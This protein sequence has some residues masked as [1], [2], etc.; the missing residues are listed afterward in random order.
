MQSGEVIQS[1]GGTRAVLSLSAKVLTCLALI[2]SLP[3]MALQ[4]FGA[5]H[6]PTVE[7]HD[8]AGVLQVEA[9]QE[10][11]AS[12]E[13][14]DE[15][16]LEVLTMPRVDA[17][18]NFNAAVLEW[19]RINEPDW[20]SAADP[21]Y[22]ADGLVVL[23]VSPE[24]RW[25]GTY[26][27]EDV[28]VGLSIQ[29]E[30]QEAGKDS[31]RI[32][33]WAGGLEQMAEKSAE[34]VG[35]PVQGVF[36]RIVL[37]TV[38]MAGGV[39]WLIALVAGRN[40]ARRRFA[41]AQRHYS[42]V[43]GDW[44]STELL[45]RTIPADEPHGAQVLVRFEWFQKRYHELTAAFN[46]F[47][48]PRGAAWFARGMP[49][50]AKDLEGRASELDSLDDTIA[51]ASAL[52]TMSSTWPEAWENEKGP[53][54]EDLASMDTMLDSVDDHGVGLS[55]SGERSWVSAQRQRLDMTTAALQARETTPS[56]AL[57]TLD[58]MSNEIRQ[59][60]RDLAKRALD[61]DTSADAEERRRR[62]RD[63]S[64]ADL[65]RAVYSG[66]WLSSSGR[67][68]YSPSSTI[69]LNPSSAG[70][71]AD[72]LPAGAGSSSSFIPVA[73]LVTGYSSASSYTAP[74]SSYSSSSFG[75][76]GGSYGGGGFSG[77]GSS[78]QF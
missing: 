43:T 27:G 74:S 39:G 69:R 49:S 47:G 17:T 58:E 68:T 3:L 57:D 29:E 34:V 16:D 65:Q 60:V 41:A 46:E 15:V 30:I 8:E 9:V 28:K 75:G 51:H 6:K 22:W 50:R 5:R 14:R 21:N 24:G 23:A 44:E 64:E 53:V 52:L 33:D 11:L 36:E 12:L 70:G 62:Y 67:G 73:G 76:G 32:G 45:A 25:V 13:F 61:A 37:P 35:R 56:A 4:P 72:G 54:L 19:A 40:T 78:S 18:E 59:R 2:A 38:A 31:F 10:S 63:S 42:S 71:S 66:V 26:F 77:A 55:T 48:S 7:V 20:I 1:L